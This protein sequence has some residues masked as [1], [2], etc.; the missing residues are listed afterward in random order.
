MADEQPVGRPGL[1]RGHCTPTPPWLGWANDRNG[2]E[3]AAEEDGGLGHDQ[4]GLEVLPAKGSGIEVRKH[5]PIGRVGQSRRIARLVMPRL[6]MGC[7]G[8]ADTEQD[9]QHLRM[10]DP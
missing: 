6:K 8:G 4:V 5:Q 9:A 1:D 7:L 10:G 3:L 2:R